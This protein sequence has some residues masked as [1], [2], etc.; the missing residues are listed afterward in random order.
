[1]SVWWRVANLSSQA[2]QFTALL[3]HC[4]ISIYHFKVVTELAF[5]T[6]VTHLLTLVALRDY[7]V[8]YKWIN[9]P[10][11][12]FMLG[13]LGLLGYTSFISYTYDLADLDL[14]FH[15]ACYF[16]GERPELKAASLAVIA[17]SFRGTND[18]CADEG[19]SMG[20]HQDPGRG[21]E[22]APSSVFRGLCIVLRL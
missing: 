7:F 17:K 15:L 18:G 8:K 12:F 21:D 4:D 13:N 6:T 22:H 3:K 19:P 5:L 1:M 10:R 16:Q 14:S 2:V 20:S 9:L 11:I